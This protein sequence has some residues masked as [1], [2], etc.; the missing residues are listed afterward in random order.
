MWLATYLDAEQ[1]LVAIFFHLEI[2][3]L[4]LNLMN[5]ADIWLAVYF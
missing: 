3:V 5:N 2:D 1:I 4:V